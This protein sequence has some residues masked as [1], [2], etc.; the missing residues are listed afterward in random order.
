MLPHQK[1]TAFYTP[2]AI[3]C[4]FCEKKQAK[5]FECE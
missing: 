5:S 1:S 3:F 4:A 2:F